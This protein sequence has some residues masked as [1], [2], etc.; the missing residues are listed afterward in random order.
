[1]S[2]RRCLTVTAAVMLALLAQT[3]WAYD[4]AET[5]KKGT[6]VL[7][8]EGGGGAQHNIEG[9]R[10]QS[11]LEFW[12]AGIRLGYIPWGPVDAKAV[13]GAFDIGLEPY[14]QRY[15]RP[16]NAQFGGLAVSFR[17]HF[18]ALGRFVPYV[19]LFGAVGGTDLKVREINSRFTFLV[20]GGLG[21][22]YFVTDRAA[23][24]LGF[25]EQHV[26]NGNTSR[27]NRG[28]ESPTGVAGI[29]F[30]FP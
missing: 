20:H 14:Y 3:A 30:F 8:L 21:A 22:E 24:Y 13:S 18:L 19:E 7:S 4:A 15:T 11:H 29:A 12:N 16:V 17:Y 26:S 23:V 27:P 2:R 28:F 5:F 25:M 10:F 6:Y 9:Q 1:M